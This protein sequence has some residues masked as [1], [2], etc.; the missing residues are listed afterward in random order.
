MQNHQTFDLGNNP[1]PI[2]INSGLQVKSVSNQD[3][4]LKS[5]VPLGITVIINTPVLFQGT[6]AVLNLNLNGILAPEN[7][8]PIMMNLFPV[9]FDPGWFT[10]GAGEIL[11][12]FVNHPIFTAQRSYRIMDGH[13][14][15]ALRVTSNTTQPGNLIFTRRTALKRDFKLSTQVGTYNGNN[16]LNCSRN[17]LD[18]SSETFSLSDLSLN[19]TIL[20]KTE[21]TRS[22]KFDLNYF[23]FMLRN[24]ALPP[25]T[26]LVTGEHFKQQ[27][28]EDVITM[29]IATDLP[30]TEVNQ[31]SFMI[32]ADYSN[33]SFEMPL[34]CSPGLPVGQGVTNVTDILYNGTPITFSDEH[35][36]KQKSKQL[37]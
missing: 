27:F 21:H 1:T 30:S 12:E 36:P 13:V 31:V 3:E 6:K 34:L 15:Y 35:E 4:L 2:E 7:A 17:A 14:D 8:T 18:F 5:F 10:T 29:S 9:T 19:R 26:T 37:L 33:V 11:W 25:V 24:T 16:Y 22:N 23:Y 32:L 20:L 28:L